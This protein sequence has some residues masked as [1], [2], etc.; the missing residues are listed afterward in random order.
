MRYSEARYPQITLTPRTLSFKVISNFHFVFQLREFTKQ[1]RDTVAKP[2]STNEAIQTLLK[3]QMSEI[4][5]VVSICLGIPKESFTW[6]F[7]DKSKGYH[8]IGPVTPLQFYEE[9]VKPAFNLDNKVN[10]RTSQLI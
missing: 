2:G 7:Y 8:K 6:E 1:I 3:W 5:R 4:F 9:Q 10:K